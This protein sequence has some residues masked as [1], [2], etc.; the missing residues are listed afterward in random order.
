VEGETSAGERFGT[1]IA[2]ETGERVR[3][4]VSRTG[5]DGAGRSCR[6]PWCVP[7]APAGAAESSK[8]GEQ[9]GKV[10]VVTCYLWIARF[11]RHRRQ[12]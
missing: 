3:A 4:K 6:A 7:G 8:S 10:T 1:V 11:V 12:R 2:T 5:R 9:S